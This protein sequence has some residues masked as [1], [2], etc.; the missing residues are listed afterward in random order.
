MAVKS[1]RWE[2]TSEFSPSSTEYQHILCRELRIKRRLDTAWV[3]G[4]LI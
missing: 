2:G 3:K 1:V 4:K